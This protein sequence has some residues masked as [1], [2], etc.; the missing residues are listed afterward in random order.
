MADNRTM[1]YPVFRGG[2]C[3]I[4]EQDLELPKTHLETAIIDM[5]RALR[6]KLHTFR[7]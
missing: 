2:N 3:S 5:N 6:D 4:P 7:T 1:P